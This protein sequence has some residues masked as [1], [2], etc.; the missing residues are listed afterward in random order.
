MSEQ[1]EPA[2][3]VKKEN[4]NYDTSEPKSTQELVMSQ[5]K[6]SSLAS[7]DSPP[8][9]SSSLVSSDSPQDIVQG[10]I[11]AGVILGA[12]LMVALVKKGII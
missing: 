4:V 11:V 8:D 7:S 5:D 12:L 1:K 3:Q 10:V 2:K 9:K 6:S